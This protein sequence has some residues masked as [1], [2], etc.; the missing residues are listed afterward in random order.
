MKKP[1]ITFYI[2]V[3]V[4]FIVLLTVITF[5]RLMGMRTDGKNEVDKSFNS[6]T[7]LVEESDLSQ[8]LIADKAFYMIKVDE[9]NELF[10]VNPKNISINVFTFKNGNFIY[11]A[12]S[13]IS[14]TR[15]KTITYENK[16][17]NYYLLY[18]LFDSAELYKLL[19][20]ILMPLIIFLVITMLLIPVSYMKNRNADLSDEEPVKPQDPEGTDNTES[21]NFPDKSVQPEYKNESTPHSPSPVK[22]DTVPEEKYEPDI[23]KNSGLVSQNQLESRLT[24]ELKRAASFD[25]DIV[26][27]VI[28]C[29]SVRDVKKYKKIA[30]MLKE[31]FIFHDLIFEFEGFS[32]AIILPNI[33]LDHGI[34][35][36]ESIQEQLVIRELISEWCT[37]IGLSSRNGRLLSGSRLI[38]EA[39]AALKKSSEDEKNC[40]TGFRSDPQKYREFLANK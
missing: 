25:Q 24:S 20:T 14:E 5:L 2:T 9:N 23:V 21:L 36:I 22:E 37:S 27:A 35:K 39:K 3:S 12:S 29:K 34:R 13:F 30:D 18:Y 31:S 11:N 4:L 19:K 33:D 6:Y 10:A 28:Y 32:Y 17:Y 1:F 38:Q 8:N 7:N 15:M 26:L 16:K 40:I